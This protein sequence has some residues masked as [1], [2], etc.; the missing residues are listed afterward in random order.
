MFHIFRPIK[1]FSLWH[2]FHDTESKVLSLPMQD[3]K[4][5]QIVKKVYSLQNNTIILN[6]QFIQEFWKK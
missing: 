3:K 1:T 5:Q 4:Q 2:N 6:F